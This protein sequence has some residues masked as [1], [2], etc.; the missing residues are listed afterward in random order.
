MSCILGL[1]LS[2]V[3]PCTPGVNGQLRGVWGREGSGF[4]EWGE[5]GR[6]GPRTCVLFARGEGW[7]RA[8]EGGHRPFLGECCGPPFRTPII[9]LVLESCPAGDPSLDFSYPHQLRR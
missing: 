1:L 5:L 9:A 8:L 7:V 2:T 6:A 3:A 4:L